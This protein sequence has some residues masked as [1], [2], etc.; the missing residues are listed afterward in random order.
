MRS[1]RTINKCRV[2]RSKRLESI[3]NLGNFYISTF[4]KKPGQ[5]IGRTPLELVK[6]QNCTLMQL[7]HTAPQELLY[8]RI[9]WYK[10]GNNPIIVRTLK[11]IAT[12]AIKIAKPKDG[13]VFLDIGAND[14]TLLKFVPKDYFRIACEPAKNFHKELED[15]NLDFYI[16]DFWKATYLKNVSKAKIITAIG[17]FYDMDDPL[18]FLKDCVAVLDKDGIFVTQ[19]EMMETMVKNNEF[20]NICHEHLE[21]YSLQSLKY[22][23]E[24]SGLEI[25]KVEVKK[26]SIDG[27][28]YR[29]YARHYQKGSIILP[30]RK[31]DLEN[32][33]R[34][35][36]LN[37]K[38][39]V[40]FIL[41]ERARNKKIYSYAA[42]TRGNTILQYYQ[43]NYPYL[44]GAADI[45]SRKWG[46]Y[47]VGTWIPIMSEKKAREKAD[48]FL[49]L[50]WGYIKAFIKK[51][52]GWLKKGGKFIICIPQFKVIGK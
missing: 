14:G 31:M 1:Y 32:F 5:N 22:L 49:V 35:V 23:F 41:T 16:F 25:F 47:T 12:E 45:N 33:K 20:S 39:T 52:K 37:R 11:E 7:R 13:D 46:K 18:K 36:E 26:N 48:Y 40:N 24:K 21:Y 42:S 6:C 43:L 15:L 50:P 3:W 29:F 34:K 27:E 8:K 44:S 30:Y 19:M 4:V 17:M 51:E 10:S 9:Y 2:C 38:Q 28:S